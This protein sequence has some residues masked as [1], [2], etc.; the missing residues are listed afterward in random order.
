M[1][2]LSTH[3]RLLAGMIESGAALGSVETWQ[4]LAKEAVESREGVT[5]GAKAASNAS[6]VPECTPVAFSSTSLKETLKER[7]D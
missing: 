5:Q 7:L 4:P 2:A 1:E 6:H 3:G